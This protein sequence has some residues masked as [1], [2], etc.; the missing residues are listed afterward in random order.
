MS[1]GCLL[2]SEKQQHLI[3]VIM[4]TCP[5]HVR[6]NVFNQLQ[7]KCISGRDYNISIAITPDE[8][9]HTNQTHCLR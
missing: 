3:P 9:Y 6:K 8:D 2:F 1:L 4:L 5:F 7:T